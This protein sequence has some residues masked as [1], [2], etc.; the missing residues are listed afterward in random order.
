MFASPWRVMVAL[1]RAEMSVQR[2]FTAQMM[3][4]EP[5]LEQTQLSY[6]AFILL[7]GYQEELSRASCLADHP[8]AWHRWNM[9]A[10]ERFRGQHALRVTSAPEPSDIIFENLELSKVKV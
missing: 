1:F 7:F 5:C 9:P 8:G 3:R 4:P 10:D 2:V 6:I